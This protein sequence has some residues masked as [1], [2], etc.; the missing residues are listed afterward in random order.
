MAN[1]KWLK[2]VYLSDILVNLIEEYRKWL[3]ASD[4]LWVNFLPVLKKESKYKGLSGCF[5]HMTGWKPWSTQD[6]I[7]LH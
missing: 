7:I 5:I 6:E 2:K 4:I 3:L 1:D